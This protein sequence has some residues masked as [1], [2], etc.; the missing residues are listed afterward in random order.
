MAQ[1]S[2]F[3][4]DKDVEEEITKEFWWIIANLQDE[5]EVKTFLGDLLTKTER[6]MIS[7]RLAIA[8]LLVQGYTYAQIREVLKVSPATVNQIHRWL[9]RGGEGYKIAVERLLKKE[10]MEKFFEKL[11][12]FLDQ[13]MLPFKGDIRSRTRWGLKIEEP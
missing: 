2:R 5:K 4:L 8:L 7:K 13:A 1:V 11:N 10:K 3:P 12:R 6:V 9:E